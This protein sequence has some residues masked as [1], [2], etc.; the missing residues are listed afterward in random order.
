M[1]E[2]RRYPENQPPSHKQCVVTNGS[3]FKLADHALRYKHGT[4]EG[5]KWEAVNGVRLEDVTHYAEL[6]HP[7]EGGKTL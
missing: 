1:I 4:K 6:D 5:Y 3:Y 7:V 2:W